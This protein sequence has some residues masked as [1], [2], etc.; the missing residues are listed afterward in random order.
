MDSVILASAP[1][2][3]KANTKPQ[4]LPRSICSSR[5]SCRRWVAMMQTK[6]KRSKN[7]TKGNCE[8]S[9]CLVSAL[10]TA[11]TTQFANSAVFP[12]HFP[13]LLARAKVYQAADASRHYCQA[14]PHFST[15]LPSASTLLGADT[16]RASSEN[17]KPLPGKSTLQIQTYPNVFKMK[18][19][20]IYLFFLHQ[21]GPLSVRIFLP[22][23]S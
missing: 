12:K 2:V 1:Q 11:S 6:R 4:S 15:L 14:L 8:A 20:H 17:P 19:R 23:L 13:T 22:I 16:G 5:A 9:P 21:L 7:K 10:V 18:N 3:D